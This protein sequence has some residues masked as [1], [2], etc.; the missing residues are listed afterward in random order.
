MYTLGV[1]SKGRLNSKELEWGIKKQKEVPEKL[2]KLD[3][4]C[5]I[6]NKACALQFWYNLNFILSFNGEC[7]KVFNLGYFPRFRKIYKGEFIL[8]TRQK[9]L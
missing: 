8:E 2:Q 3:F 9:N 7:R 5:E 6:G 4:F 1:K